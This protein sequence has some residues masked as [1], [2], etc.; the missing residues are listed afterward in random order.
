MNLITQPI[1]SN[2]QDPLTTSMSIKKWTMTCW[3]PFKKMLIKI[4]L[5]NNKMRWLLSRLRLQFKTK[6]RLRNH[7]KRRPRK[8]Q[9]RS[10]KMMKMKRTTRFLKT[11]CHH[12]RGLPIITH[13]K[14]R[15]QL[16]LPS[17][18]NKWRNLH[19]VSF[20]NKQKNLLK[21]KEV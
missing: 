14:L 18:D 7:R 16:K 12:F 3:Q 8:N 6:K 17:R 21:T 9:K 11:H 15:Q 5:I 10:E 13:R 20:T 4:N 19:P 2:W 1:S